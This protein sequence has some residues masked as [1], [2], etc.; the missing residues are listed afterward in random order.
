MGAFGFRA[1]AFFRPS[2]FGLRTW[3]SLTDCVSFVIMREE[4]VSDAL[5]GDTH[6]E[7]AGFAALFQ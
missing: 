6:F 1:S 7:Q 2:V 3:L 4:K 5:T